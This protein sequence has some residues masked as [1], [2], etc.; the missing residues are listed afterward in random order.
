MEILLLIQSFIPKEKHREYL[1]ILQDT[2]N[3]VHSQKLPNDIDLTV[4]L[5]D[6]GSDYLRSH[7]RDS[8][9]ILESNELDQIRSSYGLD[10]SDVVLSPPS[11]Y[12]LKADLFNHYLRAKGK[13]YD[14]LFFLD[15]DHPFV[16]EDCL[17][18]A[19]QHFTA[20]YELIVGRLC[21]PNGYY[22]SY[23]DRRVQ[24]T[25]F[26]VSYNVLASIGF[27]SD[28]VKVWGCGEDSDIFWKLYKYSQESGLRAIYDGNIQTVDRLTGRWRYAEK[29]AGGLEAFKAKFFEHHGVTPHNNA[30]RNKPEWMELAKDR[31]GIPEG[32][33]PFIKLDEYKTYNTHPRELQILWRLRCQRQRLIEI[34]RDTAHAARTKLKEL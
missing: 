12:Y 10:V 25:T 16:T 20:G 31:K 34:A 26:A 8:I 29:L 30:S 23:N 3:A 33:F 6:D 18:R 11:P 19:V 32:L 2:L 7:C 15:D 4:V 13:H 27:F 9:S 24:G 17:L 1:P 22:R 5:S 28:Q 14:C 21:D